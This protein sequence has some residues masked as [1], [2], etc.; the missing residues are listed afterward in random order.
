MV[1]G[2]MSL[3][4]HVGYTCK[5][6]CNLIELA[7]GFLYEEDVILVGLGVV[8]E[9]KEFVMGATP[10]V[11][12][13]YSNV[14]DVVSGP[15]TW[16]ASVGHKFVI[17]MCVGGNMWYIRAV[18]YIMCLIVIECDVTVV[19]VYGANSAYG[20]LVHCSGVCDTMFA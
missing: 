10:H 15:F 20:W 18:M 1:V 7:L 4:D 13:P 6:F 14:R 2:V 9:V 12:R 16:V 19:S 11:D 17:S 5:C 3:E 8:V